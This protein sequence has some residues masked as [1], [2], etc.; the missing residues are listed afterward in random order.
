MGEYSTLTLMEKEIIRIVKG[1]GHTN[2]IDASGLPPCQGEVIIEPTSLEVVEGGLAADYEAIR[3]QWSYTAVLASQPGEDVQTMVV[4][5]SSSGAAALTV[6]PAS[7]AFSRSNWST[8]QTVTL[9]PQID[10][11]RDDET[12]TLSYNLTTT[13][14]RDLHTCF[15]Y[16]LRQTLLV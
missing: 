15:N 10:G 13:K 7:L 6:E 16:S 8:P 4:K 14:Q 11:D 2:D 5:V 12:V 9:L 1:D 3:E